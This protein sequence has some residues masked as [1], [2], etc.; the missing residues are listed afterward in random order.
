MIV[1]IQLF[2]IG[3]CSH[4]I[5]HLSAIPKNGNL[6]TDCHNLAHTMGDDNDSIAFFFQIAENIEKLCGFLRGEYASRLIQNQK[7]YI[8]V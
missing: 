1:I 5:C 6:V 8:S 2:R 3:V 7:F 4:K